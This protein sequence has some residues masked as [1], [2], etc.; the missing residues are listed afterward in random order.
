VDVVAT[1]DN[2]KIAIEI[3]TGKSD[4][5]RNIQQDLA[6]KYSKVLVV[7]TDK[8]AFEKIEKGLAQAG[9]LILGRV[10]LVMATEF[11]LSI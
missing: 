11:R 5:I 3:E 4:F 10:G 9:L 2:E 6:A 7:A 1:K 8:N